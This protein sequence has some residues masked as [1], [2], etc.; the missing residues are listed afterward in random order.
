MKS[1]DFKEAIN[2]L[3]NIGCF[4]LKEITDIEDDKALISYRQ[5]ER[6]RNGEILKLNRI[7]VIR[8]CIA[9]RL[10]Y[11]LSCLLFSLAGFAFSNSNEDINY[12]CILQNSLQMSLE[13]LKKALDNI[14]NS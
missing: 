12:I 14:I 4:Q 10:P 8:I 9:M 3:L 5:F 6:Y 13:E 11:V 7:V 2:Y 1:M